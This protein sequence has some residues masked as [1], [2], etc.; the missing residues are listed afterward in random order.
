MR[1]RTEEDLT[2]LFLSQGAD[3]MLEK[4]YSQA[5]Q[6][7]QAAL[8][9]N[10]ENHTALAAY[11]LCLFKQA[12]LGEAQFRHCVTPLTDAYYLTDENNLA[13]MIAS[14]IAIAHGA[15]G[16][17]R[18]GIVWARRACEHGSSDFK[19]WQILADLLCSAKDFKKAVDAGEKSLKL[20]PANSETLF[21]LGQSYFSLQELDKSRRALEQAIALDPKNWV[22]QYTLADT[23]L[24]QG[25]TNAATVRIMAAATL[26]RKPTF[27]ELAAILELANR[28]EKK[29]QS[30]TIDHLIT[31]LE[32]RNSGLKIRRMEIKVT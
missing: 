13:E 12:A 11:G 8:Q 20:K 14:A 22:Y 4:Q 25:F 23:M 29:G 27:V 26:V 18:D 5:E 6:C 15:L 10:A 32:S 3:L 9:I 21:I 28:L 1:I 16:Q 30:S 2:R 31:I 24:A 17:Y 7:F 19:N